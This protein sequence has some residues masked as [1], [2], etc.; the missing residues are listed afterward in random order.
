MKK[1]LKTI[2]PYILTMVTLLVGYT[3]ITLFQ[4]S[5]VDFSSPN[6]ML[7]WG[8]GLVFTYIVFFPSVEEWFKFWKNILT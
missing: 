8:L 2:L 3:G 5:I 4:K 7:K 1:T 6:Q